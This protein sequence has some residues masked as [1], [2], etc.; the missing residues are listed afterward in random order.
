MTR[1]KY[2]KCGIVYLSIA[3]LY[4]HVYLESDTFEHTAPCTFR[5]SPG[6]RLPAAGTTTA[7]KLKVIIRNYSVVQNGMRSE[8]DFVRDSSKKIDRTVVLWILHMRKM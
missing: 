6:V 4:S 7:I 1:H 2:T 5:T 3:A 8:D